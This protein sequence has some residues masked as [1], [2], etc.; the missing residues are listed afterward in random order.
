MFQ[1]P[2][3]VNSKACPTML[4]SVCNVCLAIV[5][6]LVSLGETG[7]LAAQ[8]TSA[9]RPA[10]AHPYFAKEE[11]TPA[12]KWGYE[13]DIGPA[14]WGML[15]PAYQLARDGKQ[16][17]PINIDSSE[18]APR[19]L[20]TLRFAY[21]TEQLTSFNNGHTIQHNEQPGS[22]LTVGAD[23]YALEQFHVHT[24]SEHTIDG[25]HFP[26]ELHLVHKSSQGA[27]AVVAVLIEANE[28]GVL[29]VPPYYALPARAGEETRFTGRR[30]PAE[31]LPESRAYYEYRGSFTTPP[32]TEG[33]RWIVLK[34][35]VQAHP[36]MID[37]FVQILK[38][39][40][41]PIQALHG[42]TVE[43]AVRRP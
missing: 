7:R 38:A 32:C 19:E 35:A 13:G 20:A 39:N 27:M 14:F 25:C 9:R 33:V 23:K 17:S 5:T 43:E 10:P 26:M 37:R 40:N 11:H 24:P 3:D 8:E 30:N 41:R 2:L 31:F 6:N 34:T 21:R 16:Q 4:K 42:R 28:N 22:F 18:A 36:E 29:N 15:N 1:C 12:A